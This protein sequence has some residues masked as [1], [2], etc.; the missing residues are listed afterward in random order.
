VSDS[1]RV[2]IVEDFAAFRSQ[3]VSTLKQRTDLTIA[4]EASNG[5]EAIEQIEALRPD[6]ILLD[7][8]LPKLNGIEV[9]RRIRNFLGH[10]KVLIVSQEN[11]DDVV[12]EA[13]AAGAHG[14]LIK[15]DVGTQLLPAIDVVLSG[16]RYV[17]RVLAAIRKA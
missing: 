2:L 6:L 10:S 13:F 11:S 14:Y 12:Q 17:G 15:A 3:L 7:L 4:G 9:M 1:I 16:E 8:G 5:L